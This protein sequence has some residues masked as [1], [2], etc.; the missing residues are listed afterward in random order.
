MR[1][2]AIITILCTFYFLMSTNVMA[3]S[4][5]LKGICPNPL[6]MQ[7]DWQPESEHG[8]IYEL[9]GNGYKIDKDKKKVS[10]A[11]VKSI[12]SDIEN[13]QYDLSNLEELVEDFS[14]LGLILSRPVPVFAELLTLSKVD[15]PFTL[16]DLFPLKVYVFVPALYP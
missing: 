6:V 4:T 3:R 13:E 5:S 2:K 15:L 8:G 12:L 14:V 16:K 9:V 1:S 11:E 10:D 7:L